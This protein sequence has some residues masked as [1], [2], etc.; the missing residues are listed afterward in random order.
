MEAKLKRRDREQ[1]RKE[2]R[3][4]NAFFDDDDNED[5]FGRTQQIRR[6]RRKDPQMEEL[7]QVIN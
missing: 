6:R 7:E 3:L 2:G 5:E 1:A 4:P